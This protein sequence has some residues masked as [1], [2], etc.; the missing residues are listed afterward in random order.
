MR[1]LLADDSDLILD[2]LQHVLSVYDHIEIVGALT[3][4]TDALEALRVLKPDVAIVDIRMPGLSGLEVLREIRK[5]NQVI[6]FII[7]TM[8]SLDIYRQQAIKSGADYFF[9][10]VDDFSKISQVVGGMAVKEG[11]GYG[12]KVGSR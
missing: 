2:R 11:N 6:K 7:L 8:Y 5:E 9:S 3:N 4:G 10:K 12:V 1:V